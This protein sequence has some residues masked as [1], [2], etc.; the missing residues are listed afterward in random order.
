M[1][2]VLFLLHGM[3]AHAPRWSDDV[4]AKLD[5]VAL[6]YPRFR[7]QHPRGDVGDL[8]EIVEIS[9][10]H[11]FSRYVNGW[12]Q[13][14]AELEAFVDVNEL[15]AG[16]PLDDFA[17]VV[18]WVSRDARPTEKHYFWSHAVDVL[19]YRFF[20]LVTDEVRVSVMQQIADVLARPGVQASVLAHSLGAKV[21][22]DALHFLGTVPWGGGHSLLA[23]SGY[24][25]ESVF[26]LANVAHV[27]GRVR[28]EDPPVYG[29]VVRPLTAPGAGRGYC[30]AFYDFRHAFDPFTLVRP[31]RPPGWGDDFHAPPPLVHIAPDWNVHGMTS[32]LDHPAVHV[33]ILNALLATTE[34]FVGPDELPALVANYAAPSLP[35]CQ[36]AV[37][38]FTRRTRELS[39]AVRRSDGD[40]ATLV[41]AIAKFH[42]AVEEARDA[43]R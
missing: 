26:T 19:L 41:I 31:F 11:V 38:D 39:D 3:G 5:E 18:N 4:R 2:R 17:A 24:A 15:H 6:R 40:L 28:P 8:L 1:P 30:T 16:A 36:Q 25:L 27:L 35:P 14:V 29:G 37:Q 32:F 10:D 20:P 42:A 9:Y 12:D 43:C 13:S 7:A 34:P 22:L 33:P 21:A 23:S